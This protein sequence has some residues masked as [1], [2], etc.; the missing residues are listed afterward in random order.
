MGEGP[1]GAGV[2]GALPSFR[3]RRKATMDGAPVESILS[4][5]WS[6]MDDPTI[7]RKNPGVIMVPMTKEEAKKKMPNVS[8]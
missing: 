2:Q 3:I 6:I 7:R 5:P 1:A 4:V 8:S